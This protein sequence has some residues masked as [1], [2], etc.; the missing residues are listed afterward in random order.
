MSTYL[1]EIGTEELP[2]KFAYSV[3]NQFKSLVEFELKKNVVSYKEI[4]CSS[5]PRRIVLLISGL[6]DS[7]K[8]KIELRKGPK[9]EVAFVNNIPT[10]SAIG[11]A[12][13]LDIKVEDL[14]IKKIQKGEFVFGE[15]LEKGKSTKHLLSLII[16]K[17]I[18]SLQGPRFMRWG[19]GNFKFS[20]PIR[21]IISLYNDQ[22]LEFPLNDIQP[23]LIINR[24]SRGHRL[25]NKNISINIADKYL[26][27]LDNCGVIVNREIRKEI[28][29]DLIEKTSSKLKLYPDL[30][31]TLLN[32]ITDL[33]ES[34]DL[35]VGNFDSKYLSLPAEVLCVVMKNHQRYIP[36]YKQDKKFNILDLNSQDTLST[37]FLLVS[38][39]LKHSK[40]FIKIGN[41]NVLKAR[42]ADAKFFI[43]ADQ[44][45][46]SKDRNKKITSISYLKGLGNLYEKVNRIIFITTN[47]FDKLNDPFIDFN[48]LEEAAKYSKHD[49]CSE[50]VNE[51]PE[52]QGIMGGKY[53][54][55]EGFSENISM[56]VAE[57]Y[58][59]RFYK[60][61][62]PS[63][64]YGAIIAI[65]D[66][67]ETIIS[68]FVTGKR[69]SG[70]SDPYALRRNLNG[71]IQ[72]IWQYDFNLKLNELILLSTNHWKKEL[73]NYCFNECEVLEDLNQFSR[74]RIISYL[75]D[76]S[77]NKE[78]ISSTCESE[79]IK[80]LNIFNIL[81]LKN[82]I[83]AIQEIKLKSNSSA[84][85]S[86]ISRYSKLAHRGT[87]KNDILSCNLNVNNELF[88]KD[89]EVCVF[90]FL[91]LLEKLIKSKSWEYKDLINLFEENLENLERIFDNQEGVLI[92]S[93]NMDVRKNRLNLLGLVR[94]YS[95]LIADFTIL[96]S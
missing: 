37:N 45:I 11:F 30:S 63:T 54:F 50:I 29:N 14:K 1:L 53:L 57:H 56:A 74:Q 79:N 40:D 55:K 66:K 12:K 64:K 76:L 25:I 81:D 51:F 95:L 6:I 38:N 94:N 41:E 85:I 46:M 24:I 34:P 22:I 23:K 4:F 68:I 75:Q 73:T 58:Y 90:K 91:K 18:K 48:E 78:I 49:L 70:S 42:F 60:D 39:G 44:K 26:E 84:L 69:P 31:D 72:I 82:R 32:E 17:V 33:V 77:F 87:L 47:I 35:I 9:A 5:T 86:I 16:P 62:L 27:A 93:E 10:K 2:A 7:G 28:I 80:H 36:L 67:L 88:E 3:V 43:E 65:S 89:S 8:D 92:M 15:K 20:R 59:P 71:I 83:K 61:K 19:Y 52:L 21:W 96:S 13:S